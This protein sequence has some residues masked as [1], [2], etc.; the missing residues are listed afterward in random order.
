MLE[1]GIALQGIC[2]FFSE[3]GTEGGIW[4][5]QDSRYIQKNVAHGWCKKCGKV[6]VPQSGPLQ[7]VRVVQITK[8]TFFDGKFVEPQDCPDNAHEED[9]GESWSYEGLHCL[10]N[11]DSLT[12]YS[13]DNPNWIH[14]S[15]TIK[16]KN[17]P[18]F[19]E[20]ASG[21]WIHA[22]QTGM[23]REVW[24]KWFFEGFPATLVI[25]ANRSVQKIK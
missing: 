18:L 14:W 11:G 10:E 8:G 25:N 6:L 21:L 3:T 2:H 12:I 22:D 9:F 17:H 7:L 16:L 13:K 5:F 19:T 24:A 23:E 4:A 1:K 20:H 15:G